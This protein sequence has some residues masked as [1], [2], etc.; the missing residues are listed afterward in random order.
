ME[1]KNCEFTLE[2]K[3]RLLVN[4]IEKNL[5][6]SADSLIVPTKVDKE[7]IKIYL[8]FLTEL[9]NFVSM[10]AKVNK[11]EENIDIHE[12]AFYLYYKD[13]GYAIGKS[14]IS[15]IKDAVYFTKNFYKPKEFRYI[16]FNKLKKYIEEQNNVG[17]KI[18]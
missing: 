3:M 15:D 17:G 9:Y 7:S 6:L 12:T 1:I 16:S 8:N 5:F 10:Y 14:N 4:Y 11:V 2:E 13:V 18:K